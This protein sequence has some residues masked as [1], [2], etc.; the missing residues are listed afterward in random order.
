MCFAL[1]NNFKHE[2]FRSQCFSSKGQAISDVTMLP[3]N[4]IVWKQLKVV[5]NFHGHHRAVNNLLWSHLA[6][7]LVVADKLR[8]LSNETFKFPCE[9]DRWIFPLFILLWEDLSWRVH[10]ATNGFEKIAIPTD[11]QTRASISNIRI[12]QPRFSLLKDLKTRQH[13]TRILRCSSR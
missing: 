4:G 3:T 13:W 7:W 8:F 1:K 10:A 11:Y 6:F 2:I 5:F 12:F 9:A